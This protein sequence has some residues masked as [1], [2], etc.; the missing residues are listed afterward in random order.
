MLN[1]EICVNCFVFIKGA[2]GRDARNTNL[3]HWNT[4]MKFS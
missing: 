4:G 3:K 1:Q 2:L